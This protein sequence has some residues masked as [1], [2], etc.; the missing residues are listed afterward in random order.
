[1][2]TSLE[3]FLISLGDTAFGFRNIFRAN[4][5]RRSRMSKVLEKIR[6][7]FFFFFIFDDP[8]LIT[9]TK[10]SIRRISMPGK[11][12]KLH[13]VSEWTPCP[14]PTEHARECN[15]LSRLSSSLPLF[16]IVRRDDAW[17]RRWVWFLP[18]L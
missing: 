8:I 3:Y 9:F 2:F 5:F 13:R 17:R 7:L 14:F 11:K 15:N 12:E 6:N 18:V 16:S 1:M 4:K 10:E